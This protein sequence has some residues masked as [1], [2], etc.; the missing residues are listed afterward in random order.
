MGSKCSQQLQ[1]LLNA[2]QLKSLVERLNEHEPKCTKVI[3]RTLRPTW[4]V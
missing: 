4:T 2:I 3:Q 1:K